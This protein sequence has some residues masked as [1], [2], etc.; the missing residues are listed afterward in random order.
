MKK[1]SGVLKRIFSPHIALLVI[2][3][4]LSIFL[5]YYVFVGESEQSAVAYLSYVL[6][7]YTLAADII[8]SVPLAKKFK[9]FKENNKYVRKYLESKSLQFDIS[10]YFSIII[11][12]GYAVVNLITSHFESSPW[13]F[14]VAVYYLT[15]SLLRL[16]ILVEF[17]KIGKPQKKNVRIL[18]LKVY[19]TTGFV[20][21]FVSVVMSGMTIQMVRDNAGKEHSDIM[22]IAMASFTFTFFAIAIANLQK[23]RKTQEPIVSASK[24]LNFACALMS[25]FTLQTSMISAFGEDADFRLAMNIATGSAVFVLVIGLAIYMILRAN[26]MIKEVNNERK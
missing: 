7:A 9:Q 4:L 25:V 26:K 12:V 20:M 11:N 2:L 3:N 10:I 22:T 14:S 6:S 13:L 16:F 8:N 17:H 18:E 1:L 24:M 19:R 23:H 5:L 21:F 15:L